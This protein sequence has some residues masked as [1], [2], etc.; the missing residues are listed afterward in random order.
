MRIYLL[1]RKNC[2]EFEKKLKKLENLGKFWGNLE[3]LVKNIGKIN[4]NNR[5]DVL[6]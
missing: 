1:F 3:N 4:Y 5:K 6:Q 2:E